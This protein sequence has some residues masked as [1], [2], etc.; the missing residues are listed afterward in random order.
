MNQNEALKVLKKGENVF[1]TGQPGTGKT[2]LTQQYI[3]Y[4]KEKN[5]SVSVTA[6]TGIAATHLNGRTIHSWS[7]IGIKD[8]LSRKEL[9]KIISNDHIYERIKR[10]KVLIIDEISMLPARNFEMVDI[11]CKE[12]KGS[13]LPF[14]GIQVILVGDFFQLPPIIKQREQNSFLNNVFVYETDTWNNLNLQICYLDE[15]YRQDDLQ[16]IDLLRSIRE[17]NFDEKYLSFLEE[18]KI[19]QSQGDILK[20]FTHNKNVDLINE[21]RLSQLKGESKS[22][23]MRSEGIKEVVGS[24]KKNCLSPEKLTLK[25]GAEVMFTRNSPEGDFVNGTLGYVK[26][27]DKE[28][29]LPVVETRD[30]L[31]ILVEPID[32]IL[33]EGYQLVAKITQLPL[34]L[35]WAITVHK[36]Q[37]M[38]LDNALIDLSKA[39]EYGQG[40]VALSRVKRLSGLY[41]LGWNSI[42]FQVSPNVLE[43]DKEFRSLSNSILC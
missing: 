7:G 43:K 1:L 28:T 17:N 3:D 36:S 38:S 2:Y 25:I 8:T 14:G 23:L 29:G 37:G 19:N 26:S 16:Y 35:A 12:I 15:Q 42:S 20:L 41:L 31:S 21:Q 5:I 4:L 18:R 30:G 32:W 11:V 34:R 6:S 22:Y 33:E 24:M 9:Y 39:F 27:F 40:Y 10:C 13:S